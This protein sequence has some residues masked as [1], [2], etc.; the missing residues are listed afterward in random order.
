MAKNKKGITMYQ[1]IE[2][3]E[4][5]THLSIIRFYSR[6]KWGTEQLWKRTRL[7]KG[8]KLNSGFRYTFLKTKIFYDDFFE[9]YFEDSKYEEIIESFMY[10]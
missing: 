5:I 1:I 9:E 2:T 4:K 8:L 7:G 3:D 10:Y 6:S